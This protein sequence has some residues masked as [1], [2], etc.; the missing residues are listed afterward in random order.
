MGSPGVAGMSA[1][2]WR[3]DSGLA[4]AVSVRQVPRACPEGRASLAARAALAGTAESS[5]SLQRN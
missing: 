2:C 4:G 3:G 5:V 1:C